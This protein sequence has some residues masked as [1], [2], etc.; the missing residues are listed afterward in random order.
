A[1]AFCGPSAA[2]RT[3]GTAPVARATVGRSIAMAEQ[4]L[5]LATLER[6]GGR[7]PEAAKLLGI[8]L[9]TLYN[10]LNLYRARGVARRPGE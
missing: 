4:E 7:K 9:K 8:S 6:L 5:I 3:G 2:A 10:R 1:E